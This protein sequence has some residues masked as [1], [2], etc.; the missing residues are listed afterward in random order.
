VV[1]ADL[2]AALADKFAVSLTT[3]A[4]IK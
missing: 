2:A 4:T 1:A 3:L